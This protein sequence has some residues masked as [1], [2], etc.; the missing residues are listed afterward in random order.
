MLGVAS[1][2]SL[3]I[4]FILPVNIEIGGEGV[5]RRFL[6]PLG[7]HKI[8]LRKGK[9]TGNISGTHRCEFLTQA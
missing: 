9:I 1:Q 8:D 4:A 6:W 5:A 3:N 2:G 7:R